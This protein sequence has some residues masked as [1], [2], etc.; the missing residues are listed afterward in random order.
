MT[1]HN[2][3]D[4]TAPLDA[5]AL[6][7]EALLAAGE[8]LLRGQGADAPRLQAE[9]LLA[10]ALSQPR[11]YLIGHADGGVTDSAAASYRALLERAA[12]GEPSAYLLGEREFWSLAL[13]VSPAVL[14]PRPETELVVERALRL[15]DAAAGRRVCDLGTGSGAIALALARERP[16]WRISATDC[17]RAALELAARNA[18]RHGLLQVELLHGDWFAPLVGRRFELIASNPPYVAADDPALLKLRH[19]PRVALT[20]GRAGTEALL[21]IVVEAPH[22]LLPGGW[23][24]L[25][26]GAGQAPR[27]AQALQRRGYV[28][29]RCHR[30]YGSI[31]RVVEAQW[32]GDGGA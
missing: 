12:A 28:G 15:L 9:L 30:D 7:I 17:S 25:E 4:A 11:S 10:H 19:E 27:L 23:L 5:R 13:E 14:V 24:V 22:Y 6:R 2:L 20:P 8:A 32:R 21:H 26:H 31:E 29:V 18:R 1:A 3:T 16:Q